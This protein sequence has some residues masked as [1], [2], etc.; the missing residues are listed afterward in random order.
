[1]EW[2]LGDH[3]LTNIKTTCCLYHLVQPYRRDLEVQRTTRLLFIFSVAAYR[4]EV[5]KGSAA[6][7]VRNKGKVWR[8]FSLGLCF[9]LLQIFLKIRRVDGRLKCL[10]WI[11]IGMNGIP[12]ASQ[13]CVAE[14][15][16]KEQ[17]TNVAGF[18]KQIIV[19]KQNVP[20]IRFRDSTWPLPTTA[21]QKQR[22]KRQRQKAV[23]GLKLVHANFFSSNYIVT[24]VG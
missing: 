9:C 24:T 23:I 16:I 12:T 7:R 13:C 11:G 15:L 22:G 6:W 5:L 10:H 3:P 2:G 21:K 1:M 8:F 18:N 19:I 17:Q 14:L 4:S 20:C